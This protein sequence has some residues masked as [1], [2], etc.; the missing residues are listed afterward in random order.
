MIKLNDFVD[1]IYCVNLDVRTDRWELISEEFEKVNLDVERFSAVEGSKIPLNELTII[2]DDLGTNIRGAQGALKSH[3]AILKEAIDNKYEKIAVFEDDLIFCDDFEGRLNYYIAYTPPDWDM[4][5]MG[6]HYYGCE[7]PTYIRHYIYKNKRNFGCFAMIIKKDM[8]QKIYD[9]TMEETKTIDDYISEMVKDNNCYSFIPFFVKTTNTVSD[10][11]IS[12]ES[13]EYDVVNKFFSN[14]AHEFNPVGM[15][16][17]EHQTI[18]TKPKNPPPKDSTTLKSFVSSNRDFLI[19][20]D[21]KQIFDSKNNKQ[22]IS[23]SENYFIV[24]GKQF[25]FKGIQIKNK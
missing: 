7:N 12:N 14:Y 15:F 22:N 2:N 3:R 1:K 17:V 16:K 5:Y 4:M 23:V 13:Y 11:S 8:I 9:Y 19:Y 25:G 24:Y 10:I 6:C 21:G 20:Q 18:K